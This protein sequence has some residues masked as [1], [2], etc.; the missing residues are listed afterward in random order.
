M[1]EEIN[2]DALIEETRKR[3]AESRKKV[4]RYNIMMVLFFCVVIIGVAGS[5]YYFNESKRL[6]TKLKIA[7][8][9]LKF[10]NDTLTLTNNSLKLARDSIKILLDLR[11]TQLITASENP[12]SNTMEKLKV[13]A[14]SIQKT[15]N[16]DSARAYSEIGY[17]KLS[18][19]KLI[20]AMYAF[21]KSEKWYN[22]YRE[23]Y[24]IYFLLWKNKKDL[25]IPAVQTQLLKK[26]QKDLDSKG[27]LKYINIK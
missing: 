21:D 22:T 24:E 5:V 11:E 17:Q 16:R 18:E 1:A 20:E 26:I 27:F 8:I 3:V 10:S 6:N 25:N 14:D 23:S 13:L 4:I 7:E 2:N 19:R 15:R 12:G 9:R